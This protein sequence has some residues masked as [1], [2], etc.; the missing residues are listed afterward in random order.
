MI[1]IHRIP[2]LSDNYV[3]V[4]A[5]AGQGIVVDPGE[6]DPIV[7]QLTSLGLDLIQIWVT[8]HH[9]DH[10]GGIPKLRQ[11][12]PQVEI[13]GGEYD[14]GRIPGQTHRLRDGDAWQ[15]WGERV[16]ILFIP[17]HTKAHIAYYLPAQGALFCGD[18]VF[19][20]GCGRLIEGSPE[21]MVASLD[22]IRQ[23]P[24]HTQIY[25]AHEY[26]LKNLQF[27]LTVDPENEALQRRYQQVVVQRQQGLATVPSDLGTERA[28]NPFLRW[29]QPALQ[30]AMDSRDPVRVFARLRGRKD[31]F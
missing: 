26:T 20:G 8:H 29:D 16:E 3:F 23:L 17:G 9:G 2:T 27:A 4:L 6:A 14:W 22:R 30:A 15:I 1:Q 31:L 25:C 5:E 28:T 19:A 12:F 11:H 13:L 21:Q 24:E 10:I 7:A 18:T